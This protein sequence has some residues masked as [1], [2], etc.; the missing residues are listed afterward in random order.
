[1]A[2]IKVN[3]GCDGRQNENFSPGSVSVTCITLRNLI[4]AAYG[5]FASGPHADPKHL[6]ILGTRDWAG[7]SHYDIAYKAQGNVPMDQVF[8]PILQAILEDR[9]Q[10]KVH[11]ETRDL[12][13]YTITVAKG[14]LKIRAS[15]EGS[16]IPL[17]LNHADQPSSNFCGRMTARAS[18]T[19]VTD[20]AY[21]MSLPAGFS[22]TDRTGPSSTTPD[23]RD[24]LTLIWNST[25]AMRR[26]RQSRS[27][28]GHGKPFDLYR[29]AGTTRIEAFVRQRSCGSS[30]HRSR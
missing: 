25:A 15:K 6:R 18:G 30:R 4:Q 26:S 13:V 27:S 10:L 21:G 11:R 1:V 9:F 3:A 2:S 22:P 16:C 12:P 24:Y 17:D 5:A 7:S 23:R 28:G 29:C 14:G 20:D 8:G 19:H